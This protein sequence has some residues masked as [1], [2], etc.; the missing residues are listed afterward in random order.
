MAQMRPVYCK[1]MKHS[2]GNREVKMP[3]SVQL[4]Y[5]VVRSM[6]GF[7][8]SCACAVMSDCVGR[9]EM[10]PLSDDNAHCEDN[11][12]MSGVVGCSSKAG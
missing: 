4:M 3:P 2:S 8:Q 10:S 12:S 11:A 6:S 9:S 5:V 1:G 7:S